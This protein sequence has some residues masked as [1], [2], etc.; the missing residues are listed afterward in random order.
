M[1]YCIVGNLPKAA[2]DA[3]I[4]VL[5]RLGMMRNHSYLKNNLRS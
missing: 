1:R 5:L 3:A 4:Y 2:V